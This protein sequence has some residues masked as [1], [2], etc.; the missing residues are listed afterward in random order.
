MP[1]IN[2]RNL[3]WFTV[4]KR[5]IFLASRAYDNFMSRESSISHACF[6]SEALGLQKPRSRSE[7]VANDSILRDAGCRIHADCAGDRPAPP[8]TVRISIRCDFHFYHATRLREGTL[9]TFRRRVSRRVTTRQR[10]GS[11]QCFLQPLAL[12]CLSYVCY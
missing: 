2:V 12:F 6:D 9:A 3:S 4:A 5:L 1:C 10:Q 8:M 7:S 11:G